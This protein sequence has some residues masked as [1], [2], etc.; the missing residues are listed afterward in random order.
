ML[1]VLGVCIVAQATLKSNAK[2][3]SQLIRLPPVLISV[4]DMMTKVH[5]P[6]LHLRVD[7]IVDLSMPPALKAKRPYAGKG[8][9]T[10]MPVQPTQAQAQAITAAIAGGG[11]GTST[12]QQQPLLAAN[13]K[14]DTRRV[15][16]TTS[17]SG[18]SNTPPAPGRL[19]VSDYADTGA[20]LVRQPFS[21]HN[22]PAVPATTTA[23]A[24]PSV[25]F[26][27]VRAGSDGMLAR[28]HRHKGRLSLSEEDFSTISDKLDG[29]SGVDVSNASQ[30]LAVEDK[31]VP[32]APTSA[33]SSVMGRVSDLCSSDPALLPSYAA[34]ERCLPDAPLPRRAVL[35]DSTHS[36]S[37]RVSAAAC[38]P[39]FDA[40][41][42]LIEDK[43]RALSTM[44][45]GTSADGAVSIVSEVQAVT[46]T[47][48]NAV[49]AA[50]ARAVDVSQCNYEEVDLLSKNNAMLV[51]ALIQSQADEMRATAARLHGLSKT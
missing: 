23:A 25:Q 2:E 6:S 45:A 4:T 51:Q 21:Q 17:S 24:R 10:Q 3:I 20:T 5:L 19:I 34:V 26:P 28:T 31:K 30:L 44:C 22:T 41:M 48:A 1:S 36:P 43:L 12:A 13:L 8:S 35:D 39:S 15:H 38:S 33:P 49:S 37:S 14:A 42:C 27:L 50:R 11:E 47:L 7:E 9:S 16:H 18:E 29:D 40:L 32:E 46:A